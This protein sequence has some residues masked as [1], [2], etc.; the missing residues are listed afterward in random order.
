MYSMTDP[1]EVWRASGKVESAYTSRLNWDQAVKVWAGFGSV[2]PD[3]AFESFSPARDVS[4]ERRAVFLP[5]SAVVD[6]SDRLLIGGRWYEIDGDPRR[7]T[8]TSR[9]HIR[10]SVWRSIR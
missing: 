1:V 2:Q 9:R 3:K 7:H 8:Q 5:L 4:Q 10:L 6:D